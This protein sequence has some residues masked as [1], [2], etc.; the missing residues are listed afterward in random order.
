LLY[1]TPMSFL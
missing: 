1:L